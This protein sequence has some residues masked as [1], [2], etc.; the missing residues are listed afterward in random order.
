MSEAGGLEKRIIEEIFTAM[1]ARDPERTGTLR[2][3]KTALKNKAIEKRGLLTPAAEQQTLATMI[4]QR[5]DSIEQFTKGNRPELAAGEGC[6][7][8]PISASLPPI[9]R[10]V[11]SPSDHSEVSPEPASA[12]LTNSLT[13]LPSARKP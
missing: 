11:Q 7:A 1:K 6:I 4:K 13:V 3:I 2:L 8:Q 5:R 9:R 10:G 12:F